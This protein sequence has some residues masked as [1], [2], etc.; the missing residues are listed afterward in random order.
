MIPIYILA[1][2]SFYFI[3]NLATKKILVSK[4][5]TSNTEFFWWAT[6]A[7]FLYTLLATFNFHD[8]LPSGD[9]QYYGLP[10]FNYIFRSILLSGDLPYWNPLVN[11][12]EPTFLFI[13]HNFLLH[14]PY[15]LSYLFSP[16]LK[17]FQP[18]N[19]FWIALHLGII[20]QGIGMTFLAQL[21][22]K[23]KSISIYVLII[24]LFS[25]LSSGQLHQL[26]INA[27]MLYLVWQLVLLVS[28]YKLGSRMYF[29]GFCWLIGYS[30]TNHYPHLIAYF[31]SF[32]FIAIFLFDKPL[33]QRLMA[34]LKG[35]GFLSFLRKSMILIVK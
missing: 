16:V 34:R 21:L 12:G 22:I 27:T 25:G 31:W 28:W 2:I 14:Y 8:T 6:G 9:N 29:L 3:W 11:Q 26:Q 1:L 35:I 7:L 5:Y 30:F 10:Y 15:V 19:V 33:L 20:L 13:N 24:A 18:H 32:F 23:N 17:Y 4:I